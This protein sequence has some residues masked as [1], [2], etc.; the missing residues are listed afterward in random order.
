MQ[1]LSQL[2]CGWFALQGISY[3]MDALIWRRFI[4]FIS[5]IRA[6]EGLTMPSWLLPGL[7][8]WALQLC[9][10]YGCRLT[11]SSSYGGELEVS[12]L[13]L[14]LESVESSRLLNLPFGML[15]R[16]DTN[17][18]HKLLI[19]YTAVIGLERLWVGFKSSA[20]QLSKSTKNG[21]DS[22]EGLS[23]GLSARDQ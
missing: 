11:L 13:T 10:W 19:I 18:F 2:I 23:W 21:S 22:V 5:H 4:G 15:F 12:G 7:S 1:V 9:L 20:I 8:A 17:T 14:Q 16:H 6:C 3:R